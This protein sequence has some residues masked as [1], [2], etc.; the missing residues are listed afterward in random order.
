[1]FI[2][3]L[4]RAILET[5]AYSNVFEY[6]LR[7][8]ELHRYLPMRV[9]IE[10]VSQTLDS[11]NGLLG[12]QDDFY[13]LA[14][15]EKI[16][17]I[18]KQREVYS[19][20]LL[21]KA[22]IYGRILGTLPFIRMVALTGSLAVMNSYKAADFDYML[23]TTPNRVWTARAFALLF[24]RLTHLLGHTLCPNLIVSENALAW[25]SHDLYSA[26]ELCQ[27]IPITGLGV[28]KKLIQENEWVKQF[29]P[30]AFLERGSLLSHMRWQAVALQSF[31]E[32]PLF[33][34]L[35]DRIERWE[36]NRKI[37]HFSKQAGFGEETIFNSDVCQGN[38]DHHKKWTQ[39]AF[40]EKL[41][42]YVLANSAMTGTREMI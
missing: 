4:E 38:F 2:S 42:Q 26:R 13:F 34:K 1:M 11:L 31:L 33:S 25:S 15:H 9:E 22:L 10:Q 14:G 40:D 12:K 41:Q 30:N 3:V 24:N 35:G 23:V 17:E 8:D 18:R 16:V 32:F 20:K 7:L 28:Y 6:P 27:M 21:H 37:L 29:L 39:K 19:Q 36:M 5:L